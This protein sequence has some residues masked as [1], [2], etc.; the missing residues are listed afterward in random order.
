M[1]VLYKMSR[2][3]WWI[4]KRL[5]KLDRSALPNIIAGHEIVPELL[6]GEVQVARITSI[7]LDLLQNPEKREAQRKELRKVC[8]QL[9]DPG[10]V[11][12]TAKLV[13]SYIE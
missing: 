12:R 11:E 1:I 3:S 7:A 6:Q 9:G 4:I 2:L 10:A 5:V 8:E 13:L